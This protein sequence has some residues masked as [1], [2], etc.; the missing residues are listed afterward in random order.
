MLKDGEDRDIAYACNT[1]SGCNVKQ[2]LMVIDAVMMHTN[3]NVSID[4][5]CQ[6]NLYL[7]YYPGQTDRR[8][9]PSY[10]VLKNCCWPAC[11]LL[12]RSKNIERPK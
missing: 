2:R 12:P 8:G 3:V 6:I 7:V 10:S 4:F 9:Q 1:E 5:I 11:L